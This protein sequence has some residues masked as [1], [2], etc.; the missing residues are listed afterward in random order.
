MKIFKVFSYKDSRRGKCKNLKSFQ[1]DKENLKVWSLLKHGIPDRE[2]LK[3]SKSFQTGK[4]WKFKVFYDSNSRKG[5]LWK[6]QS[7]FRQETDYL[8]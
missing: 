4:T 5:K 6:I 8:I 3:N 2:N 7:L 1:T